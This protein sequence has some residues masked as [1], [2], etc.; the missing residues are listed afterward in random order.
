MRGTCLLLFALL[1]LQADGLAD[2]RAALGRLQGT[3]PLKGTFEIQT[4]SRQGGGKEAV[5]KP[6]QGTAW[7]EDGPQG[8]KLHWNRS[9]LAQM[10]QEGRAQ[11]K[12]PKAPTPALT[13]L[14]S[15]TPRTVSQ[16]IN[17]AEEVLN[18]MEG[19]TFQGETREVWNGKP[20]R[21]LTFKLGLT[22]MT[23]KDKKMI[24]EHE[25]WAKVWVDDEGIPLATQV[26]NRFK[27]RALMVISFSQEMEETSTFAKVGDRLV[28]T[29]SE[30]KSSGSGGG[31]TGQNREVRT[32]SIQ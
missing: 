2:L 13:G 1:P 16:Q 19:A 10:V 11:R 20:A 22:G 7:V 8:L 9:L 21:L 28:C 5:E 6:G 17:A 12:D 24:K 14:G 32:F 30:E 23:E 15:L 26:K 3:T 29:R 18:R 27:G 25:G 4:W 31:E